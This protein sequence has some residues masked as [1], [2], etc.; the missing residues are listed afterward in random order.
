[1]RRLGYRPSLDGLRAVA[2]LLVVA[3]LPRSWLPGGTLGV[4]LFFV[5]S[6][7]LIT[8][9]LLEERGATG[10][11]S[12]PHFYAR[13]ALRLLPALWLLLIVYVAYGLANGHHGLP[14]H[15]LGAAAIG[16]GHVANFF[17]AAGSPNQAHYLVHLWSLAQEEQFYLLWP[18][19]L[20]ALLRRGVST[21]TLLLGFAT[22]VVAVPSSGGRC[23]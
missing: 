3:V 23:M 19:V 14:S 8:T 5:L 11:V 2:I 12:L 20:L 21:R 17:A 6:G 4:D 10:D 15:V 22:L 18:I 13:R 7:F 1:M 16:A 9:L